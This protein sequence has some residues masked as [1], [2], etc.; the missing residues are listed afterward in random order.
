MDVESQHTHAHMVHGSRCRGQTRARAREEVEHKKNVSLRAQKTPLPGKCPGVPTEPEAQ[1]A[2]VTV[3]NVAAAGVPS[4]ATLVLA[5]S[6]A[7]GL[8]SATLSLLVRCAL[9]EEKWP[10]VQEEAQAERDTLTA[11]G[12]GALSAQQKKRLNT[13]L[14]E[15]EEILDRRR[16]RRVV[17]KRRRRRKL[18]K[19][20][21]GFSAVIINEEFQQ[22][23]LFQFSSECW[24]FQLRRRD[25]YPQCKLCSWMA[26][27]RLLLCDDR[28]WR[29]SRQCGKLWR[30]RSCCSRRCGFLGM[31][32]Y[33]D[34]GA[35]CCAELDI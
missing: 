33:C 28:C 31:G 7:D 27:T 10:E 22:F 14:D 6:T 35:T 9:E 29:W 3:G 2:A 11:V 19:T 34:S 21:S 32:S 15:R 5:D 13:V 8:D 4:L 12:L 25:R 24:T 18:P 17:T 20:S 30:F 1:G 16:R 23:M 26:V